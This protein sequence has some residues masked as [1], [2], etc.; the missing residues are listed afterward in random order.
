MAVPYA[1]AKEVGNKERQQG[2]LS[3][4]GRRCCDRYNKAGAIDRHRWMVFL[5]QQKK[6][7]LRHT[8]RLL[9]SG[10]ADPTL[11]LL[12]FDR[13]GMEELPFDTTVHMSF[14]D[15]RRDKT[16]FLTHA[17]WLEAPSSLP[18][19]LDRWLIAESCSPDKIE[20]SFEFH[21]SISLALLQSP[22]YAIVRSA[23]NF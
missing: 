16:L 13:R 9:T 14:R 15:I 4:Q 1:L 7:I 21:L 17:A 6:L 5:G 3:S 19:V 22:V 12:G 18:E 8:N 20:F 23:V 10:L 2:R 11:T